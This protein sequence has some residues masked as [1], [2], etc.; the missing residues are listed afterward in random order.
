MLICICCVRVSF[1]IKF[2]KK[3]LKK[4]FFFGGALK[5]LKKFGFVKFSRDRE[6]NHL[7]DM[8]CF[9]IYTSLFLFDP[10]RHQEITSAQLL[11]KSE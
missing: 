4:F 8:S 7:P 2:L 3:E 11:R 10:W 6:R 9:A 5:T 1:C